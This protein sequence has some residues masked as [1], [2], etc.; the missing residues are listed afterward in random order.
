[1]GQ[2]TEQ[3]EVRTRLWESDHGSSTAVQFRTDGECPV[4]LHTNLGWTPVG[5]PEGEDP[6]DYAEGLAESYRLT[7]QPEGRA[8]YMAGLDR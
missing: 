3:Q 8:R 1:M 5:V 6:E 2:E 7:E 4:W